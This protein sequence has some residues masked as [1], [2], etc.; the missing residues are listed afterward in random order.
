MLFWHVCVTTGRFVF[1]YLYL[2]A[3]RT[4]DAALRCVFGTE[5]SNIS[6]L[7]FITYLAAAGGL[8]P[9]I[10]TRANFGG[11]ELKIVVSWLCVFDSFIFY[12]NLYS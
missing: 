5:A 10:S 6:L 7:F 2:G 4:L 12:T 3:K 1:F 9:L 11:Q 8:D